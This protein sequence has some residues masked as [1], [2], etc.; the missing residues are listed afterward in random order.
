M[1]C[2][3]H[4]FSVTCN[5]WTGNIWAKSRPDDLTIIFA[6][7]DYVTSTIL[8]KGK[9]SRS[10]D[11][12]SICYDQ[13]HDKL[14]MQH[15]APDLDREEPQTHTVLPLTKWHHSLPPCKDSIC[16]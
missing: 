14:S 11:L 15:S 3:T 7:G 6:R 12:T 16:L 8:T 4:R 9:D 10:D 2:E 13:S 5:I 1:L